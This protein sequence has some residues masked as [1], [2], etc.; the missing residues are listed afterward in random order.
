MSPEDAPVN[1][2]INRDGTR[3]QALVLQLPGKRR[4]RRILQRFEAVEDQ[5]RAPGADASRETA[6]FVVGALALD[7]RRAEEFQRLGEKEI[8]RACLVLARSL[9]V[10]RP[11]KRRFSIWPALF[12]HAD[13]PSGD[14]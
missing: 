11:A 13:R 4:G 6:A 8:G 12:R 10:E 9:A 7:R 5:R 14:E 2:N 1:S 3:A